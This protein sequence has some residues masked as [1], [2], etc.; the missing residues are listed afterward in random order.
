MYVDMGG[1][2]DIS[3]YAS[4]S[5]SLILIFYFLAFYNMFPLEFIRPLADYASLIA[6]AVVGPIYA[7][8]FFAFEYRKRYR[9]ILNLFKEESTRSRRISTIM[10]ILF[11]ATGFVLML[12][13]TLFRPYL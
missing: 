9:E 5:V 1:G 6:I 8:N 11:A 13:N 7:F 4:G 12:L 2:R 10:S 3:T